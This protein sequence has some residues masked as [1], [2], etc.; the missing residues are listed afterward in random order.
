MIL[1]IDQPRMSE[2]A[3][4][5]KPKALKSVNSNLL[6]IEMTTFSNKPKIS[7]I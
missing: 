4:Q 1:Y 2:T 5:T 6:T 3:G 7:S